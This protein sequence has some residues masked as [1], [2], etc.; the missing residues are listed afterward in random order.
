MARVAIITGGAQGLGAAI[1]ALVSRQWL[2]LAACWWTGTPKGLA[3]TQAALGKDR[4]AILA[5]DLTDSGHARKLQLS[6]WLLSTFGR[7][8]VLGE[9]R[10][11]YRALVD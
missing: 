5:A 4:C 11:Q 3:A 6:I 2:S 10:R 1:A 9:C 7:V 8:D